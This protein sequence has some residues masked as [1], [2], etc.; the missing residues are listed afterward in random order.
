MRSRTAAKGSPSI[1]L[2][3]AAPVTADMA[4]VKTDMAMG[5]TRAA[6]GSTV[7]VT[8][9]L[10][11]NEA[12]GFANAVPPEGGASYTVTILRAS[13]TDVRGDAAP[14]AVDDAGAASKETH[15]LKV[16]ASGKVTFEI[17]ASDP[18]T[19]DR[20]NP[21]GDGADRCLTRSTG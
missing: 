5:V 13:D 1:N 18:D 19:T 16:D 2:T 11:G 12:A 15:T 8:I 3:E 4:R 20:N 6:F 17:T 14:V 7:T 10:V 9:Q 21:V